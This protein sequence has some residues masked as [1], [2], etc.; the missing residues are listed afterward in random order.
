M[1]NSIEKAKPSEIQKEIRDGVLRIWWNNRAVRKDNFVFIMMVIFWMIWAPV[2]VLF[3]A[4]L[5]YDGPQL[6]L[7]IWLIGG[8][9]GTIGIPYGFLMRFWSEWVMISSESISFGYIGFLAKKPKEVLLKNVREIAIGLYNEETMRTLNV[10]E[11]T[12][13][14][15]DGRHLLGYWLKPILKEDVFQTIQEFAEANQI[16]VTIRRF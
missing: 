5:F 11:E 15:S 1:A 4:A 14:L 8:W 9:F 6:F 7:I 13:G 3:T 2:T 12:K 16:P 10:F